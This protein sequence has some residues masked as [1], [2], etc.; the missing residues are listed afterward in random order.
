MD[1]NIELLYKTVKAKMI[2]CATLGESEDLDTATRQY[3]IDA[4]CELY[5]ILEMISKPEYLEHVSKVLDAK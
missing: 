3:Y 5:S 2:S 4:A 1:C